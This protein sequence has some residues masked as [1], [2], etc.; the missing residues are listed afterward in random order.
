M[1]STMKLARVLDELDIEQSPAECLLM[2][3]LPG[4]RWLQ[5]EMS[6]GRAS[7]AE[8]TDECV[9]KSHTEMCEGCEVTS[10][11]KDMTSNA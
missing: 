4:E 8:D 9:M 2:V 6:S 3:L 10:G 11:R 5:G 7:G 1:S